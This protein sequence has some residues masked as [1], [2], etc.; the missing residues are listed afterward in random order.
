MEDGL[1]LADADLRR[2]IQE[3]YPACYE[4]CQKRRAFM[5]DVLGIELAEEVLPLSNTATLVPPFFLRPQT[6]FAVR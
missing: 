4:R 1:V 3:L 5:T 6:V 2:R